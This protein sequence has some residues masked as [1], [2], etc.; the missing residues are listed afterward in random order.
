MTHSPRRRRPS[1]LAGLV[2]VILASVTAC[3]G[4]TSTF[5]GT[6]GGSGSGQGGGGGSKS[7]S[8]S[9]VA[10]WDEDV[11]ATY[12]WKEL[13]E[14][15]GYTVNVQDLDIASTFTGVSNG[16]IDLYLDAWLPFT[17]GPYWNR[18]SDKLEVVA[19]WSEGRNVL[20]VPDFV[21][22]NSIAELKSKSAEFGSRLVGIEAGAGEMKAVR[23]KVMPAYGLDNYTLVEGSSPAM[24]ATL[25]SSI[26]QQQPVVVT[27]WQ[28]HWAFN[29]FRL[30]VL[31]DPQGAW[32]QPDHLQVIATKGWSA[33]HPE[34][35]GWMKNFK[36]SSDQT[37]AL[38][39]KIQDA[40]KGNEQVGAKQWIS[41]NQQVVDAWFSGTAS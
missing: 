30:K 17:H 3:S 37:A 16:Q 39:L 13:L 12:M 8:M 7:V 29:R 31:E 20:A 1:L 27:L 15:R 22:A 14:Q 35:A 28:P 36:L 34:L 18:F 10:G 25:D 24:L 38:M 21:D 32:G 4:Q 9:I 26:K 23:E 33:G 41:E 6:F 11:A 5:G 2:A 19:D 40:G